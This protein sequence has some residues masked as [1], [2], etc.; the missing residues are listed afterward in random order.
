[1]EFVGVK[2]L[3]IIQLKKSVVSNT[4]AVLRIE[5]KRVQLMPTIFTRHYEFVGKSFQKFTPLICM[6]ELHL[7]EIHIR[8]AEIDKTI[9]DMFSMSPE[10]R[11]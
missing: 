3:R 9:S 2:S 5:K 7:F 4:H 10:V 11:T 1:L 6:P 8:R